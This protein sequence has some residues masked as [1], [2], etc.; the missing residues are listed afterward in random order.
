MK[1][2]AFRLAISVFLFFT[3]AAVSRTECQAA[4]PFARVMIVILENTGYVDALAQPFL[5]ELAK[6]GALLGQ[7]Y[8][9]THPSQ[10]N[11]IALMA[12]TFSGVVSNDPVNLA[13]RHI[14]DLLEAQGKTWKV[15]AEAYPGNCFLGAK[16]GTYVRK[17]VPFLSFRNVQTSARRCAN[18]VEASVLKDDIASGSLP[19]Y[20]LYIPDMKND[21]H[22]TGVDFAGRWLDRAFGPLIKD[23]AFMKGML[24]VVTFDEARNNQGP[25]HIYTAFVGDAVRP[26]TTAKKRYDHYSLLRT[27]EDALALGTLGK[28][29]ESA[30]PITGVWK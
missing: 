13:W 25:N 23:R 5:G 15:Y 6:S 2:V 4:P 22:D 20:S 7:F 21:G 26:G 12:G 9:E 3:M 11:Y 1:Y 17:H 24:L 14:G 29:D 30:S 27:I 10:P 19:G 16:R 8:A 18:I 28:N